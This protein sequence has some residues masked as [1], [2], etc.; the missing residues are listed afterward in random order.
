[1]I[2]LEE[3][4]HTVPYWKALS[5]G[6]YEPRGLSCGGTLKICQDVLKSANLLHKWG[7]VSFPMASIVHFVITTDFGTKQKLVS[8]KVY[9]VIWPVLEITSLNFNICIQIRDLRI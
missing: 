8:K 2:S 1:M 5:H 4:G 9:A 3:K 7:I 6:K